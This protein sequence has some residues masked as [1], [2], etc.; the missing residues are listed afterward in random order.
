VEGV[1]HAVYKKGDKTGCSNYKGIS[2]LPSAYKILSNI[3]LSMLTVYAEE[4]TGDHQCG[5][6]RKRSATDQI[7]RIPQILNT[8]RTGDA[9]LGF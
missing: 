8:L 7:F 1:D 9:D 2:L 4:I 3:L 6:L 5:F